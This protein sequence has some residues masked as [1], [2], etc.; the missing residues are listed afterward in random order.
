VLASDISRK[1]ENFPVKII[2]R[3][4]GNENQVSVTD[5]ESCSRTQYT[6]LWVQMKVEQGHWNFL[7]QDTL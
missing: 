5:V 4:R 1:W 7:C 6:D 3:A 2:Q